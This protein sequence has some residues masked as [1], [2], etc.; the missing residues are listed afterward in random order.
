MSEASKYQVLS[1]LDFILFRPDT[2]VGSTETKVLNTYIFDDVNKPPVWRDVKYNPALLKLFDEVIQ[3]SYDH[4][5]RPEGKHLNRIDVNVNMMFGQISVTDNGGI[6]VEKHPDTGDYIPC[7][8]FGKL[9]SS[10]NYDDTEQREGAGRNGLG[11]KLTNIFSTYFKVETC[12]G[13]NEY[14]KLYSNNRKQESQP[15]ISK[16]SKRY[17]KITF[18][19]DY[20]RLKC[21]LDADN[22][23]MLIT[24]VYEIAACAKNIDVYIN[25]VKVDVKGF[26]AFTHKF[27]DSGLYVENEHWRIGL[28]PSKDNAFKHISFVN[29]THTWLG[30]THIDY[31]ADQLVE[32]VRDHIKKKTKQDIKPAEIKSHFF[33]LVDC[34]VHN[35]RFNSQTKEFMNLGVSDYGTSFRFDEKFFKKLLKSPIILDIIEWAENKKKLQ[36][37]A[38]LKKLNKE[39]ST[40]SFKT[41]DK[42]EPATQK[43]N[44][45]QCILFICEGDSASNPLISARDPKKHGVFPMRGKPLNT[46]TAKI[47]DI[48]KNNEIQ[49]L[50]KIIGLEFGKKPDILRYGRI[51]NAGDADMD[52]D[53]IR[54]LIYY[55]FY[56]QWPELFER[57]MIFNMITPIVRVTQGKKKHEFFSMEAYDEWAA[58]QTSNFRTDYL[59]G[60][61][62]NSTVDFKK[63]MFEDQYMI[64][65]EIKDQDDIEALNIA[66]GDADKKKIW[67]NCE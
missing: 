36:D 59:K 30:G 14:E 24:R 62:G 34:T 32:G 40:S 21:T 11:S 42:Y 51:V 23:G 22:Y 12:D 27:G 39:V 5:K 56:K 52:G 48:K 28:H 25:G 64:K 47:E 58:K 4:S 53:H 50:M 31:L 57:G 60:L 46:V 1:E 38:D 35:P 33:L 43:E 63:F 13:T 17:T 67:L 18:I 20:D 29:S 45:E 3:N 26:E 55:N 8:I 6:P 7:L 19:P 66:F 65:M 16:G 54:A 49:N 41:I 44:R 9:R 10:S 61:G 2:F 15:R 37:L